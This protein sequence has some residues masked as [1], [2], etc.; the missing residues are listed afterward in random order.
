MP[1]TKNRYVRAIHPR[2]PDRAGS[3]P[4]HVKVILS[5]KI[6]FCR[7]QCIQIDAGCQ[8][9]NAK[10]MHDFIRLVRTYPNEIVGIDFYGPESDCRQWWQDFRK[11]TA[12]LKQLNVPCQGSMADYEDVQL[13]VDVTHGLDLRR[14]FDAYSIVLSPAHAEDILMKH[15]V[16]LVLCPLSK[17]YVG[18]SQRLSQYLQSELIG[19]AITSFSPMEHRRYLSDIYKN[20]L[21]TIPDEF[22]HEN[23]RGIEG[24]DRPFSN[25][26]PCARCSGSM[27]ML[28]E[29]V[30]HRTN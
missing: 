6:S 9:N 14:L 18:A 1:V 25:R 13:M 15:G 5:R 30:L 8:W 7:P 17:G 20:L 16:G 27:K 10:S 22:T 2:T 24:V 11:Y 28:S 29:Q 26:F 12:W 3:P 4:V 21:D 19:Y 23:V